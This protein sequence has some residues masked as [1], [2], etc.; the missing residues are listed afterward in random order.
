MFDR[1]SDL[2]T[3]LLLL[4]EEE[5]QY[6]RSCTFDATLPELAATKIRLIGQ[7]EH[8]TAV[9]A[10]DEQNWSATL[11]EQDRAHLTD[12]LRTFETTAADNRAALKRQ[13][14]LSVELIGAIAAEARRQAG[15]SSSTYGAAGTLSV[16]DPT[17]PIAI[18]SRY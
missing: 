14:D 2:L 11:T 3:S 8:V 7:L 6:I 9:I 15:R 17:M 4:M 13:I 12:M 18:N 5:T 10:R 1:L 16:Y